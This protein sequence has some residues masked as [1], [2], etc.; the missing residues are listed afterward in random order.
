MKD[1]AFKTEF[2]TEPVYKIQ[3][4]RRQDAGVYQ[5]VARNAVGSVLSEQ[6]RVLVACEYNV[7][8]CLRNDSMSVLAL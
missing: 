4:I 6:A 1:G 7:K 8:L 5:C 2:S 3:S